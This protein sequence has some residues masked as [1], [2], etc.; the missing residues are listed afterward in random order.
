M[1]KGKNILVGVSGGIAAY[2]TAALVRLLVKNS[3]QVKV[4][5][6]SH[7]K[8]FIT[9]L[10]LATLSKNPILVDFFDPENGN[11]N[12]HVSL[13]EWADLF[14]I[15][16]AT[17]NTLAK[18][19]AGIADNLLLTTYLSARCSVVVC[20]S[21]DLDMY[22][23]ITTQNNL[24]ALSMRGVNIIEPG[25]G[26]LASGLV[27]KGR[28]AEP[29][30]IA[31]Y[32]IDFFNAD[33]PLKGKKALVTVGGTIEK[34]DAVR[35][36]SNN[37]TGKMGYNIA[38]Q[39][40]LQGAEVTIVHAGIIDSL[41]NSVKGAKEIEALCAQ[42]MYDVVKQHKDNNDIIVM[43]A[44][45]ADFSV[46]NICDNKIKKE[47]CDQLTLKLVKTKDIAAM[48]GESIRN[49]QC[50]VGFALETNDEQNNAIK[51]LE[52]KNFDFIVLNSLNDSGAGFATDTNKITIYTKDGEK[53]IYPLKSK[54]LVA[55][56]IVSLIIKKG[57]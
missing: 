19:S 27:G 43:A 15:A 35:Y 2:K 55:K 36:I 51:K 44:A 22:S 8:E 25:N 12:S 14:I 28:M 33:K 5:M 24:K 11:W 53:L 20:P 29:E 16:P 42:Q 39:L 34:I 23:H 48:V 21:M 9:P 31:N 1:L 4:I 46:E 30:D 7:A 47:C 41:K 18:M 6:T 50:F 32:I 52:R 13:A 45:V 10:T 56:D 49:N 26:E 54:E 17:A 3:A 38:N 57:F 40:S 37:S